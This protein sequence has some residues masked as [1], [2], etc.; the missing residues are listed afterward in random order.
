M[1]FPRMSKII[2]NIMLLSIA[3][4]ETLSLGLFDSKT[5]ERIDPRTKKLLRTPTEYT[6]SNERNSM[7]LKILIKNQGLGT[8]R[9]TLSRTFALTKLSLKESLLLICLFSQKS[10]FEYCACFT[11]SDLYRPIDLNMVEP[12]KITLECFI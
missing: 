10:R 3:C 1:Y 2:F 12:V 6:A 7:H 8:A 11:T 5:G 9:Y 4:D